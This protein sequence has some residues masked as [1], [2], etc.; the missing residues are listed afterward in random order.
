[1]DCNSALQSAVRGRELLSG[2]EG[3]GEVI[4]LQVA[5]RKELMC[6][7]VCG[8]V[9]SSSGKGQK[10]QMSVYWN[11]GVVVDGEW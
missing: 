5:F 10:G 1:M 4:G 8:W 2:R 9:G 3:N 7:F 11:S 6:V